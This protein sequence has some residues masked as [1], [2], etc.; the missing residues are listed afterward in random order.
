MGIV[1]CVVGWLIRNQRRKKDW[2]AIW[3]N[4][5]LERKSL[6]ESVSGA[7][8]VDLF[9]EKQRKKNLEGKGVERDDGMEKILR[10]RGGEE[11]DGEVRVVKFF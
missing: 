5:I 7:Y 11:G 6:S 2:V 9:G 3:E 10:E 8:S 1:K 4:S